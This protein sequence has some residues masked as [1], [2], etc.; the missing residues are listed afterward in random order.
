MISRL[1]LIEIVKYVLRQILIIE[2]MLSKFSVI[3][4]MIKNIMKLINVI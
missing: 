4:E 2:E 1:I 3:M